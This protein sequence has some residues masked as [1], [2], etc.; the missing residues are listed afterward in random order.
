MYQYVYGNTGM[1][2]HV[3]I[4][5]MNHVCNRVGLEVWLFTMY[6]YYACKCTCKLRYVAVVKN[7]DNYTL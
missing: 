6:V 4:L 1:Y 3:Y 5:Y 2:V 7:Y